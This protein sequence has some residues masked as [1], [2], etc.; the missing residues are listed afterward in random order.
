[1]ALIRA[2]TVLTA[3]CIVSGQVNPWIVDTNAA[4]AF[5]ITL[6]SWT[7]FAL[8]SASDIGVQINGKWISSGAGLTAS[9]YASSSGFDG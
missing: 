4:G 7:G 6:P 5:S 8:N 3:S 2:A 9:G 1:M